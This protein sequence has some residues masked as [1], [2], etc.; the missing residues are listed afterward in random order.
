MKAWNQC[1]QSCEKT[2]EILKSTSALQHFQRSAVCREMIAT[3]SEE[4]LQTALSEAIQ[5]LLSRT[6]A[7]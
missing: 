5:E 1:S 6:G 3:M 7:A 4:E 2:S